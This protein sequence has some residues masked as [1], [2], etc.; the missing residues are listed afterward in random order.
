M[1]PL[2]VDASLAVKWLVREHDTR[3]AN[4]LM[5]AWRSQG[6]IPLAPIWCRLEVA[7]ILLKRV[8]DGLLHLLDAKDN[9][10][11]LP[12]FVDLVDTDPALSERALE[13]ALHLRLRTI[14]DVHYLA[15]AEHLGCELW[16]ADGQF[17]RAVHPDFPFVKWLGNVRVET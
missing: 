3:E 6:V 17:W 15:L 5:D 9:L 16:T 4:H 13:L 7:N 10:R 1:T 14:Y 8:H 11:E 2:V 12:R